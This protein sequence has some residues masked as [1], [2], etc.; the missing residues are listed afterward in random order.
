MIAFPEILATAA[1]EAGISVPDDLEN[2]KSEDFPHWD[3]YVTVQL[4]APMP[5]PTAHWEN[6]KVIA[7]IPA[8]DIMKVTYEHL[9]ELGLAVGH[10]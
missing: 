2:Y 1:K 6:A 5:S 9:Q 7:G 8:D 3:V 10:Q 4:G